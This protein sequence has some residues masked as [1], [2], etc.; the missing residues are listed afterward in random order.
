MNKPLT[1][2]TMLGLLTVSACS[3][4]KS[5]ASPQTLDP[6]HPC[7]QKGNCA[8]YIRLPDGGAAEP[9]STDA[10]TMTMCGP[11]NG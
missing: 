8:S 1:W 10:G 2:T 7:Y 4:G 3:A 6:N 11:C 5:T 9:G